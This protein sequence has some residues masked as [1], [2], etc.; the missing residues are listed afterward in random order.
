MSNL[1][2]GKSEIVKC[3]QA[4]SAVRVL[5]T[6]REALRHSI[7]AP[8]SHLKMYHMEVWSILCERDMCV[9]LVKELEE[10]LVA[11]GLIDEEVEMVQEKALYKAKRAV[12]V[13]QEV[14]VEEDQGEGES[15]GDEEGDKDEDEPVCSSG[16]LA[17]AKW[18]H[19][20]Q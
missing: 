17:K 8:W 10:A 9:A 16:L 15:G 20:V 11:E 12:V 14:A 18:K 1:E 19:Q 5:C 2:L 3:I 4:A 13:Q 7:D 6:S